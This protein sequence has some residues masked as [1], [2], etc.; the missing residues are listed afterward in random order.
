ML[1]DLM[2][3]YTLFFRMGAPGAAAYDFVFIVHRIPL[4]TGSIGTD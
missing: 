4:R 3:L 1:H 2:I